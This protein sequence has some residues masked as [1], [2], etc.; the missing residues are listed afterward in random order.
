MQSRSPISRRVGLLL[1]SLIVILGNVVTYAQ[2][3]SYKASFTN[4]K[5]SIAV[6]VLVGQSRVIN[7]DRPVGRFSVSNPEIAEAVLVTPDQ[8]LVNGK[9]SGQVNFIAWEQTGGQFLVFDVFVRANLSLIDSQIRAL[10]PKDDIRLS[11]ANGSVVISGSAADS[12]TSKQVQSVVE[13]AGFKTVNML[14][15]PTKGA[16]QVQL[17][18]RVAEVSRNRMKDIGTSFTYQGAPSHGGYLNSGSGPSGLSDPPAQPRP[19]CPGC[20]IVGGPLTPA[21]NLL[22]MGGNTLAMLRMLQ[23]QGAVRELAEPN[24]IAMDGQEASFL[25]G[26]EFPI[27]VIQS[28][29]SQVGVTIVFKEYGVRLTFKPTIIDEDH[30]RLELT[31]E[32]STIDFN[33]GV[34]FDG[35]LIPGLL[36]RRAK[37]GVEL[38]DGQSF[39]LAGLLDNREIKSISEVPVLSQV[40][41]LG[42]LFK[43]KSFQKNETEL[44]FIVTAQIV[45]P[46]NRDDIPQMRGIDG[47]KN[48]SPLGLE[49]KGEGISG[50]TGY[51]VTGQNEETPKAVEPAKKAEPK[52][53]TDTNATSTTSSS[54][55]SVRVMNPMLPPAKVAKLELN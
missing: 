6:N 50:Q 54:T 36:T 38:R 46:V 53:T 7:F 34:K 40:P 41:I 55:S 15:S 16:T 47:L 51:K 1:A 25:A 17:Q 32:V 30:I 13:A 18:V 42:N 5:E 9:G 49:P 2:E 44:M 12:N 14:S 22:L 33:T 29:N 52:T 21:L 31:P 10:F 39:A 35:F 8:V 28:N 27:P 37:T 26:G 20:G 11:Q 43:S 45:K 48:G 24:I 23:T 3:N 4:N 19:L